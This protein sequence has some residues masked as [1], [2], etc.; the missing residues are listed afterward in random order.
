M[1]QL[2]GGEITV[3][4]GFGVIFIPLLIWIL[5]QMFTIK[6]SIGGTSENIG[7]VDERLKIIEKNFDGWQAEMRTTFLEIYKL[8]VPKKINPTSSPEMRLLNKFQAG[9]ITY[10]EAIMLNKILEAEKKEAEEAGNIL[11]AV[12]IT[13]LLGRLPTGELPLPKS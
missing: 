2:N 8:V 5:T 11:A 12:G 1:K 10:S 9:T 4:V 6:G 7:R 13:L 3:I